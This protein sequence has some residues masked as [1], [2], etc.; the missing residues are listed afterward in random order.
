MNIMYITNN[1]SLYGANRSMLDIIRNLN[2]LKYKAYVLVPEEKGNIY[3]ELEQSGIIFQT[4]HMYSSVHDTG[5]LN[6]TYEIMLKLLKVRDNIMAIK[7][8]MD[9]IK[10][11]NID[12]VHTNTSVINVGAIAAFL[13]KRKHVWH[14]REREIQY[15]Y[16]HDCK[17]IDLMLMR[18]SKKKGFI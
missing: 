12:I 5:S 14:I 18:Y 8:I 6:S 13:T 3:A 4:I 10:V 15:N 9:Y 17:W 1:T 7:V 16:T 11:W 2:P